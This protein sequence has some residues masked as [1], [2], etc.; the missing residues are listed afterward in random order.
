[1]S[2]IDDFFGGGREQ[3]AKDMQN[4]Y[5]Q[6]M[7]GAQGMMNPYIQ[8]GNTAYDAYIAALNQGKNP[9]DLYNQF[10]NSYRESPEALAQVQVGQKNANNAAAA[11]GMIGSGAEQTA[12]A[13]LAQSVR[14]QDFDKYMGNMYNT[15]N[16]YLGGQS[17]LETQ[18]FNASNNLMQTMQKYFDDMAKARAAQDTG[19][20]GGMQGL[21]GMGLGVAGS[22]FGGPIGGALGGAIGNYFGNYINGG[23]MGNSGDPHSSDWQDPDLQQPF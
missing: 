6:G 7:A 3:A 21:A 22:I 16:E 1:M 14:S 10:A 15:R 20:A 17:G 5:Q 12:A 4:Q 2:W 8:R 18:G 23:G 9:A 13:N 11:S 19:R